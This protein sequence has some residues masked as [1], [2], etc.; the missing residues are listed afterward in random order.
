MIEQ[1]D[2]AGEVLKLLF[3]DGGNTSTILLSFVAF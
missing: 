1:S 2:V 3:N